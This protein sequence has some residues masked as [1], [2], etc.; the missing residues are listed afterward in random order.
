MDHDTAS[1][2]SSAGS[3]SVPRRL[4]SHLGTKVTFSLKK[5]KKTHLGLFSFGEILTRK[6]IS[7]HTLT[8][9]CQIYCYRLKFD[10]LDQ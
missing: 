3:Y 5:K 1:E 4:T 10:Y 2:M 9:K 7:C 8:D 6:I